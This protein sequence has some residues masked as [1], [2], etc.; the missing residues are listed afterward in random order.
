MNSQEQQPEQNSY[1]K[2]HKTFH[3]NNN[4]TSVLQQTEINSSNKSYQ[5][6]FANPMQA[7]QQNNIVSP[8]KINDYKQP[9]SIQQSTVP[10]I[11]YPSYY[12]NSLSANTSQITKNVQQNIYPVIITTSTPS[13]YNSSYICTTPTQYQTNYYN[14]P[15]YYS[16]PKY[17]YYNQMNQFCPQQSVTAQNQIFK[18]EFQNVTSQLKPES[19]EIIKE[20]IH[21]EENKIT[22]FNK[23][24]NLNNTLEQKINLKETMEVKSENQDELLKINLSNQP[25][26]KNEESVKIESCQDQYCLPEN[27]QI[28]L[29]QQ[30]RCNTNQ[31]ILSK[32]LKNKPHGK[33]ATINDQ[34]SLSLQN[35]A[36]ISNKT[37]DQPDIKM[38][39]KNLPSENQYQTKN[40]LQKQKAQKQINNEQNSQ[41]EDSKLPTAQTNFSP[42]NSN[43]QKSHSQFALKINIPKPQLELQ[44]SI[45]FCQNNQNQTEGQDDTSQ[46]TLI[47][48]NRT[49]VNKQPKPFKDDVLQYQQDQQI[50]AQER[51]KNEVIQVE[52]QDD[53]SPIQQKNNEKK[54]GKKLNLIKQEINRLQKK[55]HKILLKELFS[56]NDSYL[57]T[58]EQQI[59]AQRLIF[60]KNITLN[61]FIGEFQKY[62]QVKLGQEQNKFQQCQRIIQ[63]MMTKFTNS[64]EFLNYVINNQI[65]SSYFIQFII[66]PIEK[67]TNQIDPQDQQEFQSLINDYTKKV[68]QHITELEYKQI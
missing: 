26:I 30:V 52:E 3:L 62:L 55:L 8:L 57:K 37:N 36:I 24:Q 29:K 68:F 46:T 35:K 43:Q 49:E 50:Y 16:F 10:M 6:P 60:F 12:Q 40:L 44:N 48:E 39:L 1:Q 23:N 51:A 59:E 27:S 32:F 45:T 53:Q 14:H 65:L 41:I 31:R 19:S 13:I 15:S 4:Q 17:N 47:N 22:N 61:E 58:I 18:P 67:Y 64:Q 7:S 2:L 9:M 11:I 42:L 28:K 38:K 33:K 34:Q 63:K 54:H 21:S 25:Q 56:K 20:F 5:I 66:Q